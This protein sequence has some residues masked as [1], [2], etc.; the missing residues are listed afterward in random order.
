MVKFTIYI[1]FLFCYKYINLT[2]GILYS[3]FVFVKKYFKIDI[4]KYFLIKLD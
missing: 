1:L 3:Y 4:T 2:E